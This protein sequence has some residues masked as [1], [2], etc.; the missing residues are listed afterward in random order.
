MNSSVLDLIEKVAARVADGKL[1]ATDGSA[2]LRRLVHGPALAF[3]V[4]W[5]A[6]PLD[7]LALELFKSL[8]PE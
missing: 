4:K 5:T 2:F 8:I 1:S 3:V 6:T 7:D